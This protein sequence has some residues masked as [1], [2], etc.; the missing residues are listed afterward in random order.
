MASG[1]RAAR[2]AVSYVQKYLG[3]RVR[4]HVVPGKQT[5][6]YLAKNEGKKPWEEDK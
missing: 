4:T 1:E 3:D 5:W 6:H 2:Y